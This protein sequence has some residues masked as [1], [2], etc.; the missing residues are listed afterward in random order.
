MSF[1]EEIKKRAKKEIK[2][3]VLPEAQDTRTLK[4]TEQVLKEG[5]AKIILVGDK[6]EIE[7]KAKEN[8]INIEGAKIVEP[9]NSSKYDEYV[10]LLFDLRKQK[11][12]SIEKAKGLVKDPVYFGMLMLKD[13]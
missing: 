13:E 2:T 3:I 8:N 1:I 5:Y 6:K 10:N 9:A 12:M 7:E 11:G 4:A